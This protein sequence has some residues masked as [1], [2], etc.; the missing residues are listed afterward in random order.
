MSVGEFGGRWPL[1][2]FFFLATQKKGG[3]RGSG[4]EKQTKAMA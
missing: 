1:F 3:P 4:K 2:C